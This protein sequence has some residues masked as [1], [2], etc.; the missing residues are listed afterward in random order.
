MT[1][2]TKGWPPSR[3]KAQAE[4]L[5][6][7]RIWTRATGPRTAAGKARSARNA[8]KHGFRGRAGMQIVIL[9]RWQRQCV[10]HALKGLPFPPKPPL[11]CAPAAD[12]PSSLHNAAPAIYLGITK[13]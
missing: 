5:R 1:K 7:A 3:R 10:R 9:L 11:V 13:G 2:I 6:R 8:H 4:R 12:R